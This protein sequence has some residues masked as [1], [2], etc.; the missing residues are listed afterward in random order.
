LEIR[1]FFENIFLPRSG[2]GAKSAKKKCLSGNSTLGMAWLLN[3]N[4]STVVAK[5]AKSRFSFAAKSTFSHF[6]TDFADRGIW[7]VN[8]TGCMESHILRH[9]I[10]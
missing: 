1:R 6:A 10:E 8:F 4:R 2:E 7:F 5:E 9:A 3:Q